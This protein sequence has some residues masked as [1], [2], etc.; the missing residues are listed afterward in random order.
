M[1]KNIYQSQQVT[2]GRVLAGHNGDIS[3]LPA[4]SIFTA[5]SLKMD[6]YTLSSLI[7]F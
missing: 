2:V 1:V 4:P 5:V 3:S 7:Y 6:L